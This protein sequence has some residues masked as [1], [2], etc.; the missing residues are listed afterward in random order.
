MHFVD[1][2]GILT[3]NN[4]LTGMNIY[5]Q[6]DQDGYDQDDYRSD[7]DVKFIRAEDVGD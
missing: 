6:L 2:K 7:A 1:A 3:S 4:G 5:P